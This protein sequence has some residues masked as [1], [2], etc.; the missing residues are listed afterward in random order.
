MVP[1]LPVRLPQ[2]DPFVEQEEGGTQLMADTLHLEAP[3]E[4]LNEVKDGKP[5]GAVEITGY[6]D[7]ERLSVWLPD[8]PSW[9][10]ERSLYA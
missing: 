8:A 1:Y 5:T 3:Y 2:A 4:F 10:I 6:V 7:G 9:L